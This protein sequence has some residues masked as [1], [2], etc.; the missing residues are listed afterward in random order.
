MLPADSYTYRR[1]G[2][3]SGWW[4]L[5]VG[6]L[7]A[8]LVGWLFA[9]AILPPEVDEPAGP[10]DSR[11]DPPPVEYALAAA[12]PSKLQVARERIADAL[13]ASECNPPDNVD[14][15]VKDRARSIS[16]ASGSPSHDPNRLPLG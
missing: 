10:S 4:W 3:T 14:S 7:I 12:D 2:R 8:A 13:A 1:V 15:I 9:H 5:A 6:L 16:A 11:V